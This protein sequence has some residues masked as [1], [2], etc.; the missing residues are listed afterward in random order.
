MPD[1]SGGNSHSTD[2]LIRVLGHG[3]IEGINR[4]DELAKAGT[5]KNWYE[6]LHERQINDLPITPFIGKGSLR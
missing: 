4:V 3:N 2:V 1:V 6:L 5:L